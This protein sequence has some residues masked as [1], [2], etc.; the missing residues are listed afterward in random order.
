MGL[1]SFAA[2]KSGRIL[3]VDDQLNGVSTVKL[4]G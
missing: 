4:M 1:A 2:V 3:W